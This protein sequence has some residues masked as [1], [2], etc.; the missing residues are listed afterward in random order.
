MDNGRC[1]SCRWAELWATK[2]GHEFKTGVCNME[3]LELSE[4]EDDQMHGYGDV[5]VDVAEF[6][7]CIHWERR[8][9]G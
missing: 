4:M 6:F 1:I 3:A 8:S 9:D 2:Q 5:M 7:G